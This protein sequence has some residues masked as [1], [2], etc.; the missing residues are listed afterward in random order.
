MAWLLRI[1]HMFCREPFHVETE[2]FHGK[3]QLQVDCGTVLWI[4]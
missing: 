1:N 3:L 4:R 2:E